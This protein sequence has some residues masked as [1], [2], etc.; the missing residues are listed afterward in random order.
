MT[1]LSLLLMAITLAVFGIS[2]ML[3]H[4]PWGAVTGIAFILTAAAMGAGALTGSSRAEQ[5]RVERTVSAQ[6]LPNSL[7]ALSA[8]AILAVYT[9]GY[10]R[11]REAAEK[12]EAQ[13]ARRRP[14]PAV[15]VAVEPLAAP[16][17]SAQP[18]NIEQ[19][20]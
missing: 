17:P 3:G 15:V 7:A 12:L 2:T 18:Q 14:I 20:Q 9:A 4:P 11:T 8:T 5:Y 13:S 10:Y 6:R 16:A 19:T 1:R